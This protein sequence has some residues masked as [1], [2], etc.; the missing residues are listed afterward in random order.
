MQSEAQAGLMH[1]DVSHTCVV[2]D[3][4]DSGVKLTPGCVRWNDV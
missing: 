4:A 3:A 2:L 1:S